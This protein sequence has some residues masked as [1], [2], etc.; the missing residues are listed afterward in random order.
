MPLIK[1]DSMKQINFKKLLPH[2]I[3]IAVFLIITVIFCKP[4]LETDVV[5]KQNDVAGWQGMS[6]QSFLYKE[7]HGHF[8]LWL[9][10]MFSGMPAYQVAL[11]GSWTPLGYIDSAIQLWLPQPLNFFFLACISFYFLCICLRIRPYAA[12][13]GA[14]GFAYSSFSPIIITAGHNTQMLALAYA[15]AV[16]GAIIL[17]FDKK[18]IFH[19]SN[20]S[21][22]SPTQT[23]KTEI[24]RNSLNSLTEPEPCA[25]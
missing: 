25:S 15:P 21:K 6:H 5:L 4:A 22:F 7:I 23:Q 8:P 20:S 2:I 1:P 17:I 24:I 12:I 14:L 13:L 16:I 10:S 9:T 19:L 11:E 18:Y 3:A